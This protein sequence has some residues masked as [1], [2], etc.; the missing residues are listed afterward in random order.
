MA[1][2]RLRPGKTLKDVG[3]KVR[4]LQGM[5]AQQKAV[6]NATQFF[7]DVFDLGGLA[8]TLVQDTDKVRYIIIPWLG[9]NA[10]TQTTD[11]SGGVVVIM[12]CAD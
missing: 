6:L 11:E 2:F 10:P 4:Q 3:A 8:V 1:R 12:G 9:G 7:D 5:S